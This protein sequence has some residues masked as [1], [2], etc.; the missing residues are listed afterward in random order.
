MLHRLAK[1]KIPLLSAMLAFRDLK[2]RTR[3]TACATQ[4][5]RP[6]SSQAAHP[7]ATVRTLSAWAPAWAVRG[8]P[9][10]GQLQA[11]TGSTSETARQSGV[12][13]RRARPRCQAS[14]SFFLAGVRKLSWTGAHSESTH[15]ADSGLTESV[16]IALPSV[17]FFR[18]MSSIMTQ[19]YGAVRRQRRCARRH[20]L[21]RRLG[22]RP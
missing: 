20:G 6:P 17:C 21:R 1:A 4:S 19:S 9:P 5:Q 22:P 12:R 18:A 11:W 7:H 2:S 13:S 3:P 16:S 15:S 14:L 10:K 8:S